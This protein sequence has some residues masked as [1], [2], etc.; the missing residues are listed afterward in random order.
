MKKLFVVLVMIFAVLTANAQRTPVKVSDL[1]KAI[2][3]NIAKNYAGF[4]IREA[5][6][7]VSN[8]ATNFEV[9]VTKGTDQETLLYDTN[10]NFVKKVLAQEGSVKTHKPI[11]PAAKKSAPVKGQ[12]KK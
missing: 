5:T 3:D 9:V 1:Q 2:T 7:V 11:A 6:K 10:G 12:V 4:T 8:N